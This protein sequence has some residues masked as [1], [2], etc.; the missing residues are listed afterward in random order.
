M[1]RMT[2][3]RSELTIVVALAALLAPAAAAQQPPAIQRPIQQAQRAQQPPAPAPAE[4][5]QPA[6]RQVEAPAP[7]AVQGQSPSTHVVQQGETLWSLAQQYLGDPMLWP[8]L[9]RLNTTIVED[10]HWIY[11]GE[12]LRL[13]PSAAEAAAPA[14]APAPAPTA[15]AA[16]ESTVVVQQS[17]TVTPSADTT[18]A[19]PSP[20]TVPMSGPTIF[21]VAPARARSVSNIEVTTARAYRAVREGEYFSS[22]F[23][24]EGQ[25]LN[26]G[27]IVGTAAE[28][29]DP[30][31]AR[32]AAQL[33]ET[34]V[35]TQ[36]TGDPLLTGDLL[37]VFRRSEEVGTFGQ[38]IVPTGLLRVRGAA[39]S[40]NELVRGQVIAVYG[41]M[42]NNQEV[43][44][45]QPF[46]NNSNVR[47]QP[48]T[49][50]LEGRVVRLREA[51][52]VTQMQDVLFF[53]KGAN[54]GVR[55]GDMMQVYVVRADEEHGG[56]VEQDQARA[57]VVSTR[58]RTSTAVIVALYRG[59]VGPS[60]QVR[61]VRRMPS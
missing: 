37:L 12:E 42:E 23:L 17:V 24:T 11:P 16:G 14:P 58:S 34:L 19:A 31:R 55:L 47:P 49:D 54:D 32:S 50:G 56:T 44:K 30:S 9:Y 18:H 33:F 41:P 53:D 3:F 2:I 15:P 4:Q 1:R 10:P 57:I 25:S 59:D 43:L 21:S 6:T 38:I 5:Q 27:R 28:T 22:G 45:V 39:G 26:T 51:H 35:L 8:E 60:S 48:V 13:T 7:G 52:G 46:V 61:Q 29:R 36:P 20:A 40:G